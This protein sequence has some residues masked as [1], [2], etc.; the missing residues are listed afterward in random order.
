MAANIITN[1]SFANPINHFLPGVASVQECV[2]A[3]EPGLSVLL[4][5]GGGRWKTLQDPDSRVHQA[6]KYKTSNL[7]EDRLIAIGHNKQMASTR[8]GGGLL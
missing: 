4:F 2:C 1:T 5:Q 3:R 7:V 6:I 8:G